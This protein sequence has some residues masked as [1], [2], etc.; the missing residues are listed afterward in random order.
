MGDA[1]APP[2]TEAGPVGRDGYSR[3]VSHPT[4]AGGGAIDADRAGSTRRDPASP[5]G[6]APEQPVGG[7]AG[8]IAG[9]AADGPVLAGPADENPALVTSTQKIRAVLRDRDFRRLWLVMSFSSFGDWLGLLATTALAA[10]LADGYAAANFALGGVLVVRLLPAVV[11]GP[12]AGAFAD[13]F[14][15]RKMMVVADLTRFVLFASIPLAGTL[16]WLLVASFLIECVSLFWIP[17][18]E[19]SVPNLV[20]RDQLEAA[21]QVS[22]VTTYG[23][24]PVAAALVFSL[25]A[26]LTRVLA[27]SVAFF[28]TNR[29][30]LALYINALTFLVSA[31]TVLRIRRISGRTGSGSGPA[32]GV[33]GL[34]REGWAFIGRTPLVRGL[35]IGIL[36]AFAAGGAV[37]GTGKTYAASLGGGDA[38]YGILFGAVFV[39]LGLGIGLGPKVA[40]DLSRRRLF[41]LS[42]TF[43]GASLVLVAFMPHLTLSLICVIGVGFGAGSAYLAAAT[44]LGRE[45]ADEL[46]GRT[47]AFVQSLVR[48]DLILTLAAAPFLV[49]VLRQR[50]VDLGFVE[51]TVDGA[52]ILL[53]L[54]G[55]LAI[56][57]GMVS[58]RQMDDRRG[59]PVVPDLVSALRGDTTT[60][61][62]LS[63]GGMLVAFEGGEGSGKSTQARKLAE[64]LTERGVAVTTTHEP[65]ATD[66]GAKVRSILLD[67]GDGSLT[68]R[69][70]ALL[71]AADR[72]HHVDTVIRPALDRGEVVITDRYVDSSLAYQGA[73]RALSVEDIRRLSRWATS[74]LRPDLTV[75]LDV[76]PEVGLERARSAGRGQD[77][78]ERESIDFHQR[79]RRA[80]RSLADSAPDCY[81]V[82]DAGRPPAAVSAVIRAAVGRRLA[83]R[84]AAQRPV[85]RPG[86][87]ASRRS[88]R[89]VRWRPGRSRADRAGL[90]R[91]PSAA[92]PSDGPPPA[93][94]PSDGPPP[95]EPPPSAAPRP[96]PPPTGQA[97][98]PV[99]SAA[100]TP[101]PATGPTTGSADRIA[102]VRSPSA[103]DVDGDRPAS[104]EPGGEPGDNGHPGAVTREHD[105]APGRSR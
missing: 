16:W 76:D 51:F 87:R 90:V 55:L 36:G 103:P 38:T 86:A 23:I 74:G 75:L 11:F 64:W 5:S 97:T 65:G 28:D 44:L 80:F 27:D 1:P 29:V 95:A 45:V 19:A 63:K 25:L 17:A 100:G 88:L 82:V 21:N 77:R 94:P 47:F 18:K 72:A 14:D 12:L 71:F 49:G 10:E 105:E 40:R 78:L 102:P 61:R 69:A 56:V 24:T 57:G 32:P 66:F 52:R 67:S 42:I 48:V 3:L 22:L 9:T 83:A 92:P 31:L 30:D 8:R 50:Q 26:L 59:V 68:P 43:A 101:G 53:A 33:F 70:E 84:L 79:V 7:P 54:A 93:A 15:R 4:S 20:R 35:V 6:G 85:G 2:S 13:R 98:V 37:I 81:L 73:G 58:Y 41:G 60:Q 91:R 62:R 96:G 104:P 99:R 46:R 89:A 39:G 34:L